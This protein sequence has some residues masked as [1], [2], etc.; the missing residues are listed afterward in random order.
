MAE[1]VSPVGSRRKRFSAISE[2]TH[3]NRQAV[4]EGDQGSVPKTSLWTVDD[5]GCSSRHDRILACVDQFDIGGGFPFARALAQERKDS[6]AAWQ[7]QFPGSHHSSSTSGSSNGASSSTSPRCH[8]S[9]PLRAASSNSELMVIPVS[10]TGGF[11]SDLSS[12]PGDHQ[13]LLDAIAE[14]VPEKID[15]E[16][17][18]RLVAPWIAP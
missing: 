9:S 5:Y 10:Q 13:R 11:E 2:L 12:P 6:L 14:Y 1:F 8:A 16:A 17:Q 7:S 18:A 15:A 4:A 3:R